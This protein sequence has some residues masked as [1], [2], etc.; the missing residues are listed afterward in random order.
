MKD[1]V[2]SESLSLAQKNMMAYL[3]NRDVKYIAEDAVYRNMSTG[4]EYHGRAEIGAFLHFMYN[5]AFDASTEVK[6]YIITEEHAMFDGF[7]TGIHIG[8]FRG[9][10]P[11]RKEVHVPL[12]VTYDL[13]KGLIKEARIYILGDIMAQQLGVSTAGVKQNVVYLARDIFQLKYGHFKDVRELLDE[14]MKKELMPEGQMQR[15]LTDF[16]GDAYRLILEQ[17]FDSLAD[18]EKALTSGMRKDEWQD[19]YERFKPH[20]ERSYREILKQV[21]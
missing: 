19:W 14:A 18:Y 11:I 3:Q 17:G 8:A 7:F 4:E 1:A 2:L 20:V 10:Q 6:S 12:S 21:F 9:I 13:Q 16:T 5:V 15:V